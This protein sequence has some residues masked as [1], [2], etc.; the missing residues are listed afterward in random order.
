MDP[1]GNKS[2]HWDDD[3]VQVNGNQDIACGSGA[4]CDS[5]TNE[6]QMKDNSEE[7]TPSPAKRVPLRRGTK[8]AVRK[9]TPVRKTLDISSHGGDETLDLS[10][11]PSEEPKKRRGR[12][13]K[14]SSE[15]DLIEKAAVFGALAAQISG[16]AEKQAK[17]QSA[18]SVKA[19]ADAESND[20][21]APRAKR[22][23]PRKKVTAAEELN[24][25]PRTETPAAK[26]TAQEQETSFFDFFAND[27]S[28]DISWYEPA[29][30][31]KADP[32]PEPQPRP[33]S[34][35]KP[36]RRAAAAEDQP[37]EP[38]ADGHADI[39]G[40]DDFDKIDFG[41]TDID[42][43]PRQNAPAQEA[44]RPAAPAKLSKE[45]AE[46]LWASQFSDDAPQEDDYPAGK[47]A[48]RRENNPPRWEDRPTQKKDEFDFSDDPDIS[49]T[50]R[51]QAQ[52]PAPRRGQQP[53]QEEPRFKDVGRPRPEGPRRVDDRP[54]IDNR[55]RVDS[56]PRADSRPSVDDRPRVDSRSRVDDRPRANN[57]PRVEELPQ[58]DDHPR[59]DDRPR[60]E[61][62]RRGDN[63]R[64]GDTLPREDSRRPSRFDERVFDERPFDERSFDQT[65]FEE[66]GFDDRAVEQRAVYERAEQP[67]QQ[68]FEPRHTRDADRRR[69]R[70]RPEQ[71]DAPI[72]AVTDNVPERQE[73]DHSFPSWEETISQVI[74]F[75]I[76]RHRQHKDGAQRRGPN[77]NQRRGPGRPQ[78]RRGN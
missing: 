33:R 59:M 27:I 28:S 24:E 21:S 74:R 32:Q 56:R 13:R 34:S 49:F 48:P 42:F 2:S 52:A 64:R 26:N 25:E 17:S 29:K 62:P 22:G 4:F 40:F 10:L 67:R 15:A 14:V 66:R 18:R 20:E 53:R 44:P 11:I 16:S 61:G 3:L 46:K 36:S 23:R 51:A 68:Q 41:H 57:Y 77:N 39:N 55:Q 65:G 50:P 69:Q 45:A 47:R 35:A 12:P 78:Q 19:S 8:K 9:T 63:R 1:Q 37:A 73:S 30:I 38:A 76:D 72:P 71:E 5:G 54:R 6:D 75:N 7:K 70:P 58:V 31:D 43:A 60:P